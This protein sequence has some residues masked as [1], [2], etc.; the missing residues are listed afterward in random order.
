MAQRADQHSITIADDAGQPVVMKLR[1]MEELDPGVGD[2]ILLGTS[3]V[4]FLFLGWIDDVYGNV[5]SVE[6]GEVRLIAK[7]SLGYIL[8]RFSDTD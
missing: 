6:T 2:L 5:S 3:P 7:Y 8:S 4:L 1:I